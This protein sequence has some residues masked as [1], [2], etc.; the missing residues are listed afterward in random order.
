[1]KKITLKGLRGQSPRKERTR[2]L[3]DLDTPSFS[4]SETNAAKILSLPSPCSHSNSLCSPCFKT[5]QC[6]CCMSLQ[7][8]CTLEVKRKAKGGLFNTIRKKFSSPKHRNLWDCATDAG[9][10]YPGCYSRRH[11]NDESQGTS[12][13]SYRSRSLE[14][15]RSK[16]HE[17]TVKHAGSRS[18]Q[19]N[20]RQIAVAAK[21]ASSKRQAY[22]QSREEKSET[23]SEDSQIDEGR[24]KDVLPF[25][26]Y[27]H[28]SAPVN[29]SELAVFVEGEYG[30]NVK[31]HNCDFVAYMYPCFFLNTKSVQKKQT[32]CNYYLLSCTN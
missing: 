17:D 3:G 26:G 8:D 5:E 27:G 25:D 20:K 28:A 10:Q 29:G 32:L 1:M 21:H 23:D 9:L 4:G 18:V 7:S 6:S 31:S 30:L 11:V 22:K 15:P 2:P 14:R 16:A 19:L 12:R 13:K 24:P